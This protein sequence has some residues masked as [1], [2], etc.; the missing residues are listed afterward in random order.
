L[1]NQ[2]GK[3]VKTLG[4]ELLMLLEMLLLVLVEG[5]EMSLQQ[6]LALLQVFGKE[7]KTLLVVHQKVFLLEKLDS[8]SGSFN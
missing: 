4:L 2:L 3:E 5:S 8:N 1:L 7:P 6:Q